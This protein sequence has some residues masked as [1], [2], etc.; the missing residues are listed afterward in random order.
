[1][2]V[3]TACRVVS[4]ALLLAS[5][6]SP[7]AA[8]VAGTEAVLKVPATVEGIWAAIDRHSAELDKGIQTGVLDEVHLHA[9]AIRDLAAALPALSKSLP[10]DKLARLNGNLKFVATL[11]QRLDAT[12]D[13][14]DK[15]GTQANFAKLKTV[16]AEL[17]AIHPMSAKSLVRALL[18][19][20][21]LQLRAATYGRRPPLRLYQNVLD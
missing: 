10:A 14:G 8:S 12:G 19:E 21:P 18:I 5:P 4:V 3:S 7:L 15:A 16:L 11:A 13:A 2:N 17:H 1:M 9:F 20:A 6:I